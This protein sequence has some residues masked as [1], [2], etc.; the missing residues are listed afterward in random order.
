M[1][2]KNYVDYTGLEH[3][4]TL[5]K[6]KYAG[7]SATAFQVNYAASA[8]AAVKAVGDNDTIQNTYLSQTN[9][10]G[11]YVPLTRTIAGVDLGNDITKAALLT[12]INVADGAQVNV[13]E[14]V[15]V[16]DASGTSALTPDAS[17]GVVID[18]SSYATK[19][20]ITKTLSFKGVKDFEKDLPSEGMSVGD[21][22]LVKYRG[23]S[24]TGE[25][26][27]EFVYVDKPTAHWEQFGSAMDLSGYVTKETYN[28]DMATKAS[29]ASVEAIYKSDADGSESGVLITKVDEAKTEINN[30]LGTPDTG[31]TLQD[32][33]DATEARLDVIE[34]E[35]E[36]S[37]KKALTDA[38]SFTT[39]ELGKLSL[40]K[41]DG[42][43][44]ATIEQSNGKVVATAGT[45]GVVAAANETQPVNGKDVADYV[46]STVDA[47]VGDLSLAE[48]GGAG[49]FVQSVSQA[50]GKVSATAIAIATDLTATS[51]DNNAPVGALA[52]KNYA[53]SCK[54]MTAETGGEQITV[55]AP[56]DNTEID[57]MF[58]TATV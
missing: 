8:G 17:K 41:I 51:L 18:L 45:F 19:T 10:A 53:D 4:L 22:W 49:K 2:T 52:A 38:K 28:A 14:K 27:A 29:I 11:K 46:T 26:N 54:V 25:L 48:V 40:T 30:K 31:K 3:F 35:D 9:A 58:S 20:D 15:S 32:E 42:P 23:E 44:I 47:K 39:T 37:I 1:A 50:N 16:K 36:G 34:G 7:N 5:L 43:F 57:K 33:I 56:L 21:V 12:A 6:E 24:G 13:L 55:M